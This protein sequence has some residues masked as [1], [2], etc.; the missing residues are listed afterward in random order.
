MTKKTETQARPRITRGRAEDRRS[1]DVGALRVLGRFYGL[2]WRLDRA[3][4]PLFLLRAVVQAADGLFTLYIPLLLIRAYDAGWNLRD[5]ALLIAAIAAAK[6]LAKLAGA[7]MKRQFDVRSTV[8]NQRFPAT[9][10]AKVMRLPYAALEDPEIL[11]LR[12]RAL[13]PL[14]NYGSAMNLLTAGATFLSSLLTLSGAIA[15]LLAFSWPLLLILVVISVAIIL[16]SGRLMAVVRD[17]QQSLIPINRRYGYFVD[18]QVKADFQKEFRLYGMN[19]LLR[20]RITHYTEQMR[21]WFQGIQTSQ[22]NAMSLH[23]LLRALARFA[24]YSYA[25]LRVLG[26]VWGPRIDLGQ[27]AV[28]IGAAESFTRSLE[29]SFTEL[30]QVHI[31]LHHLRPF[32]AFMQLAEADEAT[33]IETVPPLE[34][35]SF[36]HVSFHY[37]G[38]TTLVLD[39]V[40]FAFSA[41]EKIS[42]VGLNAAGK[43]TLVKLICRLFEPQSGRILWNG[44]D[45][46]DY[47]HRAYLAAL[48]AV[49]QDFQLFPFSLRD[50]I[51]T[52]QSE[53]ERASQGELERVIDEV[54]L[55]QV[56]ARL[57]AG[58]E[59]PLDKSIYEE[60]TELS[61]GERQKVAI[62]RALLRDAQLII[63][64]E[65]TAALDPLAEAEVYEHIHEL[66][67]GRTAIFISHRMS[68]SLFCDRILLLDGGR[69][70]AF[71]SHAYLM[72]D[73]GNLYRQLFETQA[74]H[75]V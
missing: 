49:F 30:I 18:T 72:Q 67:R 6:L 64:D 3:F 29:Q 58:L 56:I 40:T 25:G 42:I 54:S 69:V 39:D 73:D 36:E 43:T 9:L 31:S 51:D 21:S 60:A 33:G 27:F 45:I 47:D 44:R 34:E 65:P 24:T 74:R 70:V 23:G 37:P 5:S 15:I 46:R 28:I 71:D 17:L 63:L 1:Q 20:R 8:L 13:F 26:D 59:T 61:G 66:T 32:A 16:L 75:Y 38:T 35:L 55:T 11:D 68:S 7:A 22:G 50:N 57:P 12:E 41:G 52:A 48:A 2:I 19:R 4:I 53:A 14:A 62:A 10:A